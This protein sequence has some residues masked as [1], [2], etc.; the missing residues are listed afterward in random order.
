MRRA[1]AEAQATADLWQRDRF[2]G[3]RSADLAQAIEELT[4]AREPLSAYCRRGR[5]I[6]RS[7]STDEARLLNREV[8]ATLKRLRNM[9]RVRPGPRAQ[10]TTVSAASMWAMIGY[11]RSELGKIGR[12]HEGMRAALGGGSPRTGR[13]G[14]LYRSMAD[15]N[16]EAAKLL[17]RLDRVVGKLNAHHRDYERTSAA[18]VGAAETASARAEDPWRVL[19]EA[20]K[21]AESVATLRRDFKRLRAA[22]V[23]TTKQAQPE[24]VSAGREQF[25]R[26]DREE[27][28]GAWADFYG[29][30]GRWPR[31]ADH[32]PS[33]GL[34]HYRQL[35]R[36]VG[37]EP[38]H[39]MVE[40][41]A[42]ATSAQETAHVED[43]GYGHDPEAGPPGL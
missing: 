5:Q 29:R 26:W 15:L 28:M 7:Y 8:A 19:D 33:E 20:E 16:A 14:N 22:I 11:A 41:L 23:R 9:Q 34:P 32:T 43:N 13:N 12:D 30:H 27:I 18:R 39:Q 10:R 2:A 36:T 24:V 21:I 4:E 17:P 42:S 3:P 6:G 1:L 25:Q 40:L 31:K 37:R 35:R 38:M